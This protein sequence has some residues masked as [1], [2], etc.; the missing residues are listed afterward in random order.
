MHVDRC[1]VSDL[2][3]VRRFATGLDVDRLDVLVH[4]AGSMPSTRTESAQGHEL[5][6]A[7]HLLGPVLMTELLVPVLARHDARTI[8]VTSGGMYGQALRADDPEYRR[9]DYSPTTAYARSKRAQVELLP[10]LARRWAGSGIGVHATHPGWADTPGRGGVVAPV[11]PTD[12]P[13][14]ARRRGRRRHHRLAGRHR[15]PAA[16]GPAVARPPQPAH[17]PAAAHAYRA[18]PIAE[19]C[20]TGCGSRLVWRRDA[21]RLLVWTG[22]TRPRSSAPTATGWS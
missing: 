3:D 15:A 12:R 18:R 17:A 16:V 19:R 11:P 5:T 13:V 1:D 21:D 20:G 9:G 8:F 14:A 10:L 22:A 6:M 4:N 2:E 7:L